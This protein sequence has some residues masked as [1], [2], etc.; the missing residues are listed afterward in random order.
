MEDLSKDRLMRL[1]VEQLEKEKKDL[2][3][4]LRISAKR[5]DHLER[6]YR[7]EE[8]PLLAQDYANQRSADRATFDAL[9]QAR[10][11][12]TRMAHNQAVASKKRLGRMREAYATHRETLLVARADEYQRRKANAEKKMEEEKEKRRNAYVAQKEAERMEREEEEATA[13]KKAEAAEAAVRKAEEERLHAEAGWC[14]D[15]VLTFFPFTHACTTER[16]ATEEAEEERKREEQEHLAEQRRKREEERAAIAEEARKKAQREQEAEER[17]KQR[18]QQAKR[19]LAPAA[20]VAPE[21]GWRA[22]A[23]VQAR[24]QSP[25]PAAA[26][27]IA[28]TGPPRVAGA[29]GGG[30]RQRVA[31]KEKQAA[32]G[33]SSPATPTASL[34]P[35]S[36]KDADGFETVPEKKVWRPRRLQT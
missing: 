30:W 10:L 25:A 7:K 20:T 9:Q 23:Q 15:H 26:S 6:A 31:E 19:G 3:E 24:S 22:R 14:L 27:P 28:A 2:N 34:P 11:E 5:I 32:A 8:R 12:N 1:Q 33:A 21:G 4:R 29:S 13:R 17:A 35:E 18:T 16:R 36:K